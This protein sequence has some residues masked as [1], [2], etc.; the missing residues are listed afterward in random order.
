MIPAVVSACRVPPRRRPPHR[1]RQR[2]AGQPGSRGLVG[3]VRIGPWGPQDDVDCS[4]TCSR[5]PVP[6]RESRFVAEDRT[7][8]D[9]AAH[10]EPTL[11][12]IQA[13]YGHEGCDPLAD[14]LCRLRSQLPRV[15]SRHRI[16]CGPG[17]CDVGGP[18]VPLSKHDRLCW[19]VRPRLGWVRSPLLKVGRYG[20]ALWIIRA[21]RGTESWSRL[22][23]VGSS[24]MAYE[25]AGFDDRRRWSCAATWC[26]GSPFCGR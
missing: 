4:Q 10:C 20:S 18:S 7:R 5:R 1:P 2:A 26:T 8:S 9:S 19:P 12:V 14:S 11:P 23:F 15:L 24:S 17:V 16:A 21:R 13:G 6:S 25:F 3:E 22:T